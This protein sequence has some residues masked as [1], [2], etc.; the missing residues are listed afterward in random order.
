MAR[1]QDDRTDPTERHPVGRRRFLRGAAATTAAAFPILRAGSATAGQGCGLYST[2]PS[3]MG[4][5][6]DPSIERYGTGDA[7]A[8]TVAARA[9]SRPKA[10]PKPKPKTYRVKTG[11]ALERIARRHDLSVTELRRMNGLTSSVIRPGQVLVVGT[12]AR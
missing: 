3:F 8:R 7:S 2:P 9:T 10:E 12:R 11:D 6:P 4:D 5:V 1:R